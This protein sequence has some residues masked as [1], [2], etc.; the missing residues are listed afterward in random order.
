MRIEFPF[1]QRNCKKRSGRLR[2][3]IQ[4]YSFA[5]VIIAKNQPVKTKVAT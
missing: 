3:Y 4:S 1:I 5:F 2:E